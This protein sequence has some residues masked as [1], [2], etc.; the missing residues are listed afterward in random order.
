MSKKV[1]VDTNIFVYTLDNSS[2]HHEKCPAPVRCFSPDS[3]SF[4]R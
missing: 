3:P 2:P 4:V 1:G